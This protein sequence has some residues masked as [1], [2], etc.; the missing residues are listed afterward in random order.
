MVTD[1]ERDAGVMP[2]TDSEPTRPPCV[3][4]GFDG[5][6]SGIDAI[7]LG[8]LL[9]ESARARLIVAYVP[10]FNVLVPSLAGDP[11][12]ERTLQ[13]SAEEV[14]RYAESGLEG[15]DGW[16]GRVHPATPPA[17]G[18]HEVAEKEGADLIVVGSTH[19]H[20][21]GRIVPGTTAE[22]LL[23]GS[24]FPVL[25]A[26]AGWHPAA[27]RAFTSLGAGFD[28]SR[29]SRSALSAAAALARA[30]GGSVRAIA[31]FERPSPANPI[32]A[33]TSHGYGEIVGDMRAMLEDRLWDAVADLPESAAVSTVVL[34]G[35]PADVLAAESA[36]LD[37]LAVGSR[38]Y[39]ALRS[40]MLGTHTGELIWRSC[41]PLLVVP[42]GV[43]HPL[44][45]FTPLAAVA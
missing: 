31:A 41:C 44:A 10:P 26:P 28:G 39:G 37:L 22:K 29:Q 33:L 2:V 23:H 13:D 11:V 24:R 1:G 16:E 19:R 42:R 21:P 30:T 7:A 35:D 14:L 18:L 27:G 3:V 17:R 45:S 40:V 32:F 4:V 12:I 43:E 6:E 9:A 5:S 20:G 38:G 25:V 8:R 36:E 34:Y 15:F